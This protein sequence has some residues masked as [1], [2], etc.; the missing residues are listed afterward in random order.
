M[1]AFL[2]ERF[3]LQ[4]YERRKLRPVGDGID[5]LSYITRP[6]YLLVRRRVV[7]ASHGT[8]R[9]CTHAAPEATR[10]G[11]GQWGARSTARA[12]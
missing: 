10:D 11:V 7:G 6:D 5:F 4:L 2:A 8:H 1:E 9:C 12:G 3:H